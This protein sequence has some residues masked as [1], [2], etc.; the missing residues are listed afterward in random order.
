MMREFMLSQ[1][2]MKFIMKACEPRPGWTEP[3]AD[4]V[5]EAWDLVGKHMG[6]DGRTCEPI[7]GKDER[8]FRAEVVTDESV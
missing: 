3:S 6:F 7:V 1:K 5:N 8:Y 4:L 2:Q